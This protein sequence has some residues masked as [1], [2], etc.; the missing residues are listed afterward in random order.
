MN[1]QQFGEINEALGLLNAAYALAALVIDDE[2]K[3]WK[4]MDAINRAEMLIKDEIQ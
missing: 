2:Q 1:A 3:R 4:I